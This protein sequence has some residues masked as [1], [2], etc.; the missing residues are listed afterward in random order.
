MRDSLET[1]R[2]ILREITEA[3][4][5][6]FNW[7]RPTEQE[8]GYRYLRSAWG[9]GIAT[10]AALALVDIAIADPTTSAVVACARASNALSLRVLNKLGLE[11]IGEAILPGTSESTLKLIRQKGSHQN[12]PDGHH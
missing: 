1:D 7:T 8:V 2:L 6:H 3:D 10:E 12:S 4:A 11:L 5:E 9:R